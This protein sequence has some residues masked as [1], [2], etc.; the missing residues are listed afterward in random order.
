MSPASQGLGKASVGR[1]GSGAFCSGSSPRSTLHP[2]VL[3]P[4]GESSGPLQDAPLREGD[5]DS[6]TGT[7]SQQKQVSSTDALILGS[8][9]CHGGERPQ[10]SRP[11]LGASQCIFP[12]SRA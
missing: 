10:K 3:G 9:L 8:A 11:H 4:G 2:L 1:L 7:S 5:A 6:L 12:Q